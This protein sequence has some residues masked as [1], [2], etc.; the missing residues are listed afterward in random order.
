MCKTVQTSLVK[1]AEKREI[2]ERLL[3]HYRQMLQAFYDPLHTK[4]NI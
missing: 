3:E 4:M 2:I 1:Y